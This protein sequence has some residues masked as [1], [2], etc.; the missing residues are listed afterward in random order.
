MKK[1]L[2]IVCLL[3]ACEPERQGDTVA[4]WW[5]E[6][7]EAWQEPAECQEG[8]TACIDNG[9]GDQR[10]SYCDCGEWHGAVDCEG[11]GA[12]CDDELNPPWCFDADDEDHMETWFG[13]QDD[14][15]CSIWLQGINMLTYLCR[16]R[17][18]EECA[19]EWCD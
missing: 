3:A 1:L 11:F 12:L 4:P 14:P 6:C 16:T 8:E 7:Q 19:Q 15:E 5:A 17:I 9:Q 13:T 2:A 18:F 10:V